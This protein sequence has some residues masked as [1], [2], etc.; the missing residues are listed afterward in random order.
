MG[1]NYED[2]FYNVYDLN[3]LPKGQKEIKYIAEQL[4]KEENFHKFALKSY[5]TWKLSMYSFIIAGELSNTDLKITQLRKFYNYVKK[6]E[7]EVKG[8]GL[9]KVL[10]KL[11]F[12]LPKL[13]GSSKKEEV[14]P[15]YTIISVC[16][17]KDNFIREEED[18]LYFIEFFEAILNY[19]ETLSKEKQKKKN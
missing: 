15:L 3:S 1:W 14:R 6:M 9:P 16:L 17:K 11:K 2:S 18:V 4:Q 12:L 7:Y 13:A 10:S 19:F 5:K 8:G